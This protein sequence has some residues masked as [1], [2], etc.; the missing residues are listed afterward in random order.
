MIGVVGCWFAAG[1]L[2]V[3]VVSGVA[4]LLVLLL[5]GCWLIAKFPSCRLEKHWLPCS[6][7]ENCGC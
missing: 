7:Q 2:L 5:L 4:L 3:V 6:C 1:L